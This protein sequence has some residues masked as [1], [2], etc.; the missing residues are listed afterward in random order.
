MLVTCCDML[1]LPLSSHSALTVLAAATL[2]PRCRDCSPASDVL[3]HSVRHL[4]YHIIQGPEPDGHL[5]SRRPSNKVKTSHVHD[6]RAPTTKSS[7]PEQTRAD[8]STMR[9]AAA[10]LPVPS[11]QTSFH[12]ERTSVSSSWQA[13]NA[14]GRLMMRQRCS[15]MRGKCCRPSQAPSAA[16]QKAALTQGPLH[17]WCPW[18]IGHLMRICKIPSHG[19]M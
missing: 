5:L 8:I 7:K 10:G 4:I 16:G 6:M 13:T 2:R 15:S 12:I 19:E 3:L 18:Q 11:S 14:Q 1:S 9:K 17:N